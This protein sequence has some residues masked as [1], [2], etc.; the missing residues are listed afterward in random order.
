LLA[1]TA[2]TLPLLAKS[3]WPYYFLDAYVFGAVWW[4]GQAHP[5]ALGRR[6]IG[7]AVP[8]IATVGTLVTEYE[9]G[10]IPARIRLAEGVAMGGILAVLAAVL[11]I[12]LRRRG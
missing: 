7:A 2:L 1:L 10:A 11:T 3:V 9:M 6:L 12:R 5:L 8:L 4:L